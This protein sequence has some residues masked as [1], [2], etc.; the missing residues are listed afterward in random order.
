M[1]TPTAALLSSF[2]SAGISPVE[3]LF[4]VAVAL[5]QLTLPAK[6]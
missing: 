1:P 3:E 2:C 6:P 4:S 5:V